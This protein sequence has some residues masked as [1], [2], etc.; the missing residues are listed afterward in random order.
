[1]PK[2]DDGLRATLIKVFAV[3]FIDAMAGFQVTDDDLIAG[4]DAAAIE[5]AALA[6]IAKG[7][8][9]IAADYIENPQSVYAAIYDAG[10]W[11]YSECE[12]RHAEAELMH[13]HRN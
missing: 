13:M 5:R 3:G 6:C 2:I 11:A 9:M 8:A 1:M 10:R 7:E 12:R 4:V